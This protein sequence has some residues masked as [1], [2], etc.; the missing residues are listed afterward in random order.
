MKNNLYTSYLNIQKLLELTPNTTEYTLLRQ[1]M[2]EDELDVVKQI[3]KKQWMLDRLSENLGDQPA[4]QITCAL[5]RI[6]GQHNKFISRL[7]RT[8][9]PLRLIK[10]IMC[11]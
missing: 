3:K 8:G 4:K 5:C 7:S 11:M 10:N 2:M 1:S 9:Q 6:I